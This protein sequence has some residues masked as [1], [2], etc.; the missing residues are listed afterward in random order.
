VNCSSF[1][2]ADK[3]LFLAGSN[4]QPR[5]A[6]GQKPKGSEALFVVGGFRE[7]EAAQTPASSSVAL[8]FDLTVNEIKLCL[9]CIN[10]E[11]PNFS[12]NVCPC[13]ELFHARHADNYPLQMQL[14]GL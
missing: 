1:L 8:S 5:A 6:T 13:V 11:R 7:A 3:S 9:D 14:S 2:A 10:R 4:Y 12:V